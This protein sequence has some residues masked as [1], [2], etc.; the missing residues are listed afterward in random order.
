M[1]KTSFWSINGI[2]HFFYE[3]ALLLSLSVIAVIPFHLSATKH[4]NIDKIIDSTHVA[5][6]VKN[7]SF[8]K[9]GDSFPVYR[10]NPDWKS[11][12]G[13]I[14]IS[15]IKGKEIISSYNPLEFSW[16]M[17]RQGAVLQAVGQSVQISMGSTMGFKKG[18]LLCLFEERSLVGKVVLQEVKQN[19]SWATV[20]FLKPNVNLTDLTVSEFIFVTQV[21]ILK[22]SFLFLLAPLL[23]SCLVILHGYYFFIQKTS[24]FLFC[25]HWLRLRLKRPFIRHI[26]FLINILLGVPFVW[27]IVNFFSRCFMY[28]L[29]VFIRLSQPVLHGSLHP[30]N[31]NI[32]LY[33]NE[34]VLNAIGLIFYLGL[35]FW[36]ERSPILMFWDLFNYKPPQRLK[37][38][39][40]DILLWILHLIIFYAFGSTLF[41]FLKNNVHAIF[42]IIRPGQA[43]S[44]TQLFKAS[45]WT[46]K[47]L[48]FYEFCL[49]SRYLLWSITILGCLFGYWYTILGFFYG[50]HI[51]NTDFTIMGWLTNAICYGPLLGF[52]IWQMVPPLVGLDPVVIPRQPLWYIMCIAELLLN[53]LY[54]ISIWNLGTMFGI[55]TDKGVRT[56]G[57]YNAARHPSYTLEALM[58]V[59]IYLSGLSTCSQWLAV[60]FFI[61]IYYIRSERE[62]HFMSRSNPDY[63]LYQQKVLYK[64]I[65]G[66]Y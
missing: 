59:M 54:T 12:I 38:L 46:S 60:S 3:L 47:T 21:A 2:C 41:G 66:I 50:K 32:W 58:F 16:P 10:F 33:D 61:F 9:I 18:D 20:V 48:S 36:R 17:G 7:P 5:F 57:F 22:N 63:K 24:L 42:D 30:Y 62:D 19:D 53:L 29:D 45:Y 49:V 4:F 40:K 34:F 35:L 43:F 8:F 31:I 11:E 65:P 23:F 1:V 64:F 55:M 44:W 15:S 52:I 28:L 25:G 51:R 37:G 56:S 14:K 6:Q 26:E 13:W 39:S 27:L